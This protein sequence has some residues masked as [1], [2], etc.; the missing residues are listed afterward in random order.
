M[1]DGAAK[2]LR[3]LIDSYLVWAAQQNIPLVEGVA[4]DLAAIEIAPWSRLGGG[5]RA[6]FVHLRGRGDFLAL[7]VI[8]LPPGGRTEQ[9]RHLYEE[10]FYVL[11]GHGSIEIEL[12]DGKARQFDW[13]PN[14][15]FSPPFNAPFRLVNTSAT[16]PTRLAC[17]SD[18]PFVMNVYRNESFVFDNPFPFAPSAASASLVSDVMSVALPP[19]SEPPGSIA[20]SDLGLGGRCMRAEL[21]DLAGGTYVRGR[22][23]LPAHVFPLAGGE[24][25][26]SSG[27]TLTWAP[28]DPDFERHDWRP[29]SVFVTPQDRLH[30]HFNSGAEPARALAVSFGTRQRPVLTWVA[31]QVNAGAASIRDG[32]FAIDY[33][34]QDQRL[35]PLWLAELA[36]TGITSR[37]PAAGQGQ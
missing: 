10:V 3:Y 23:G 16:A 22:Y 2:D 31:K 34:D 11:A 12:P 19:S 37:M 4:A 28:G 9:M 1:A 36:R 7:Q 17:V 25:G 35:H 6:A 15:V 32:G 30:Q 5:V 24:K 21:F 33:E 27:Y 20:T 14:S 26:R 13:A 29:G 8:E 18:L